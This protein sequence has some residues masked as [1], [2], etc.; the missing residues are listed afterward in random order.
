MRQAQEEINLWDSW[1]DITLCPK[2]QAAEEMNRRASLKGQYTQSTYP[3]RSDGNAPLSQF[4]GTV[5]AV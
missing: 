2:K 3:A 4:K 1:K 5:P